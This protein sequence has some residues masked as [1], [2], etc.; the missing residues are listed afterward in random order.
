M[1]RTVRATGSNYGGRFRASET[2]L[3]SPLEPKQWSAVFSLLM[4][5]IPHNHVCSQAIICLK[6]RHYQLCN[7]FISVEI[8]W[9]LDHIARSCMPIWQNPSFCGRKVSPH[10]KSPSHITMCGSVTIGSHTQKSIL[11]V[12]LQV[13]QIT[14]ALKQHR[15]SCCNASNEMKLHICSTCVHRVQSL[16]LIVLTVLLHCTN[17]T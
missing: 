8:L 2:C 4:E 14:V 9:L 16:Q 7:C 6:T 11:S 12:G 15:D 17:Q 3:P 10:I 1:P 5:M 13:P